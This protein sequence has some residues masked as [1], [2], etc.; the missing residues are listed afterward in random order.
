MR[1]DV[2]LLNPTNTD[3]RVSR[4][5]IG[6]LRDQ[7]NAVEQKLLHA[8]VPSHEEYVALFASA[9]ELRKAVQNAENIFGKTYRI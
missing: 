3:A 7:L 6:G 8:R 9:A 2:A 4:D 1:A 5:I